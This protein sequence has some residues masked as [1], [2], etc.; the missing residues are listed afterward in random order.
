MLSP[1]HRTRWLANLEAAGIHPDD[2]TLE[3][4]GGGLAERLAPLQE[5]L[6]RL[7]DRNRN[8]DYLHD[9]A[10]EERADGDA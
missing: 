10:G 9:T 3:R 1:E 8:P 5:L 4:V 2:A 6:E 7:D